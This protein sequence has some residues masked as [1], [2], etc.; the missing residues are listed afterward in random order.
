MFYCLYIHYLFIYSCLD[1]SCTDARGYTP[2][3]DRFLFLIFKLVFFSWFDSH[4]ISFIVISDLLH[5]SVLI[6]NLLRFSKQN[7]LFYLRVK[8]DLK[9]YFI[10]IISS[11]LFHACVVTSLSEKQRI[12]DFFTLADTESELKTIKRFFFSWEGMEEET[13]STVLSQK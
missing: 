9:E 7:P 12:Y 4:S 8:I 10:S 11:C 13:V 2:F 1:D 3:R 6:H 5:V